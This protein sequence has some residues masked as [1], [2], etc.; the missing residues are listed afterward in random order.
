[1]FKYINFD[2]IAKLSKC[3][4]YFVSFKNNYN[5]KDDVWDL[6]GDGARSAEFGRVVEGVVDLDDAVVR[7]E[8]VEAGD[9]LEGVG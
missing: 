9:V 1:M 4:S 5:V 6:V 7:E 3:I 8:A 2:I